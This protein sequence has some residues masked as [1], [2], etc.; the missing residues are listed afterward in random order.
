MISQVQSS[1]SVL[2]KLARKT[3]SPQAIW[4]QKAEAA[5]DELGEDARASY[6]KQCCTYPTT[7]KGRRAPDLK[8]CFCPTGEKWPSR[9][10]T[11]FQQ[12]QYA[13]LAAAC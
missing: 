7:A 1:S 2:E 13:P 11:V 6:L 5:L 4:Q 3:T 10:E 9:V 12:M 8:Q